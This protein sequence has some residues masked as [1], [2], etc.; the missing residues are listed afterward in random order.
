MNR[1]ELELIQMMKGVL[2]IKFQ[3][4]IRVVGEALMGLLRY[5]KKGCR[6]RTLN[7]MVITIPQEKLKQHDMS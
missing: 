2:G 3:C 1:E 7:S 5:L 6:S 4:F